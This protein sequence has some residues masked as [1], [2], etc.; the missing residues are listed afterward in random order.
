MGLFSRKTR[1]VEIALVF[2]VGSASIGGALVLLRTGQNPHILYQARHEMPLTEELDFAR[3]QQAMQ[4]T[5]DTVVGEMVS[6]GLAHLTFKGKR[7][8]RIDCVSVAYASPWYASRVQSLSVV[9]KEPTAVS[10][11]AIDAIVE[12]EKTKLLGSEEMHAD[13]TKDDIIEQAVTDITLDGYTLQDPYG[14]KARRLEFTLALTALAGGVQEEVEDII[15]RHVSPGRIHHHSF[16][17]VSFYALTKLFPSTND[18]LICDVSGEVT[19]ISVVREGKLRESASFPNGTYFIARNIAQALHMTPREALS[20]VR[21]Y[22]DGM[23]NPEATTAITNATSAVENIWVKDFSKALEDLGGEN[24]MPRN[25]FLAVDSRVATM[26]KGFIE[27]G[28]S[29]QGQ[30]SVRPFSVV[31]LSGD[32]LRQHITIRSS[33]AVDAFLGIATL[34][35]RE[36]YS[37]LQ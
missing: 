12:K 17:L 32:K 4:T 14:K 18:A 27:R 1:D 10:K 2:D 35:A 8:K 31:F 25:I 21:Q 5:L 19:D 34:Y 20:M 24:T 6:R 11:A 9:H 16:T 15:S 22:T 3:F 28:M 37:V 36:H 23:T 7:G 26:V 33:T 30:A 13:S 29:A